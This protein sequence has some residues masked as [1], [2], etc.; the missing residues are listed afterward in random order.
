[1]SEPTTSMLDCLMTSFER[2]I[3]TQAFWEADQVMVQFALALGETAQELKQGRA[4]LT[5]KGVLVE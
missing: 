5:K 1:M 4:T 2:R 3:R